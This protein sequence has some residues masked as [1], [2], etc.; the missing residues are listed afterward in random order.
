MPAWRIRWCIRLVH[1]SHR[2]QRRD[3]AHGMREKHE[4]QLRLVL[5]SERTHSSDDA[6]GVASERMAV[7][8]G[9]SRPEIHRVEPHRLAIGAQRLRGDRT[10]LRMVAAIARHEEDE[11]ARRER[12]RRESA[13]V[14]AVQVR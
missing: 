12:G 10:D 4:R 6:C 1:Q 14:V 2:L 8:G 9:V 5:C 13:L 3:A 11:E 7:E